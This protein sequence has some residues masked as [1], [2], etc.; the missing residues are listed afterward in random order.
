VTFN[1]A[2]ASVALFQ[3]EVRA[4]VNSRFRITTAQSLAALLQAAPD[5]I[6][7]SKTAPTVPLVSG[8]PAEQAA[9]GEDQDVFLPITRR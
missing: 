4:A 6:A 3:V 9:V 2:G 1:N 8:P 5:L 7:P